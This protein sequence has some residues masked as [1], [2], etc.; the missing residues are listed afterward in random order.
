MPFEGPGGAATDATEY[1]FGWQVVGYGV[2][3][4]LRNSGIGETTH[5]WKTQLICIFFD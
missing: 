5:K 3:G 1:F 2:E 4:E